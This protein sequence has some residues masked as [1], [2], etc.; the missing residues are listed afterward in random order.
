[1][2]CSHLLAGEYEKCCVFI[3]YRRRSE[4]LDDASN[5]AGGGA[6]AGAAASEQTVFLM[7]IANPNCQ[8]VFKSNAILVFLMSCA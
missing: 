1:M 3:K 2:R 7:R 4:C 6:V 5:G 8:L